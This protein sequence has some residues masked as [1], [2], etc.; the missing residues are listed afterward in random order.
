M[1]KLAKKGYGKP[2]YCK[3]CSFSDPKL[4]DEFDKRVLEYTPRQ[5][6]E[7]LAARI[8][9]FHPV[10]NPTIYSHRQHVKHP[11]DRIVAVVEKRKLEQNYLPQKTSE[12]Q[13]L[14]SI[15]TLGYERAIHDPEA[16]TIDHALKA[17][18]IKAQSKQRG[19]AH[20]V[21][22]QIFTGQTPN[23]GTIIEGEAT[24]L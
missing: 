16:V 7:W 24:E 6:N 4:Q 2:G 20:N 14:D 8:E 5:L 10:S 23:L 17:T 12:Q 1:A 9:D 22:V 15:I 11:K 21:L 19:D 13:F 3:L 18:Q